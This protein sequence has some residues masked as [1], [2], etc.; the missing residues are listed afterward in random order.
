MIQ[1]MVDIVHA[2]MGDVYRLATY[3]PFFQ[4]DTYEF[5]TTQSRVN[6]DSAKTQFND[7][8]VVPNPL[9]CLL[10]SWET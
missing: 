8:A 3:R 6:K 5:T 10:P 1:L 7:I 2:K 4:S 9:C